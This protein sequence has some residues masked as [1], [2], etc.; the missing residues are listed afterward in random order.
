MRTPET[1]EKIILKEL[2]ILY[3][4]SEEKV[5]AELY[6]CKCWPDSVSLYFENLKSS[7]R[8]QEFKDYA[9]NLSYPQFLHTVS[10]LFKSLDK[11]HE[12]GIIH[13]DM[14]ADNIMLRE[15]SNS[16]WPIDF[17]ISQYMTED[18]NYWGSPIFMTDDKS[19][20]KKL[21][22][23]SDYYGA[24]LAISYAIWPEKRS[25]FTDINTP[26]LLC[27][28]D[29]DKMGET[30][31]YRDVILMNSINAL[32]RPFKEVKYQRKITM[33]TL[34]KKIVNI[35]IDYKTVLPEERNL[36][37]LF[38][39]MIDYGRSGITAGE[40]IS[41]FIK[42]TN[43]NKVSDKF[44]KFEI[45]PMMEENKEN[46]PKEESEF[47]K[48]LKNLH[49]KKKRDLI[50][51]MMKECSSLEK[52]EEERTEELPLQIETITINTEN[53]RFV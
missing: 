5:T 43:S 53:I 24:L 22:K 29:L 30:Y 11:I 23:E 17:S 28:S 4:V 51:N 12:M 39:D 50:R 1:I 18:N 2:T 41:E 46:I 48:Q 15:S 14:S 45:K 44:P 20:N 25:I 10:T 40:F 33:N 7:L 8:S 52:K 36:L 21:K 9:K 35:E 38:V 13:G 47:Q 31:N 32:K 34:Q 16:L 27:R 3:D 26:D 6:G 19:N 42:K 49:P 37:T